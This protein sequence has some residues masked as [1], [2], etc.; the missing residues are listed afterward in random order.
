MGFT[1]TMLFAVGGRPSAISEKRS[2]DRHPSICLNTLSMKK[3]FKQM[4]LKISE[5]DYEALE[6]VA[7]ESGTDFSVMAVVRR[8]LH[9]YLV[10]KGLV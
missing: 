10:S 5:N 6:K 9:D 3:N 7:L 2:L 8:I 1:H 4:N